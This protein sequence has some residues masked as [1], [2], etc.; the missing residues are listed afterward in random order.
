VASQAERLHTLRVK[1][2]A[3]SYT[4]RGQDWAKLFKRY[5]RKRS[6][7]ITSSEFVGAVRAQKLGQDDYSDTA[8]LRWFRTAARQDGT[9]GLEGFVKLL[10]GRLTKEEIAKASAMVSGS[11]SPSNTES[12]QQQLE[13]EDQQEVLPSQESQLREAMQHL[14]RSAKASTHE[15]QA[16]RSH[17]NELWRRLQH[18]DERYLVM[19]RAKGVGAAFRAW[20]DLMRTVTTQRRQATRVIMRLSRMRAAKS[21]AAWGYFVDQEQWQRSVLTRAVGRLLNQRVAAALAT[22]QHKVTQSQRLQSLSRGVIGRMMNT[23]LGAAFL[24]WHSW[25]DETR[26]QRQ[27]IARVLRLM[28]NARVASAMTAWHEMIVERKHL[29]GVAAR[30]VGKLVHRCVSC[31]WGAWVYYCC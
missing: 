24:T 20:A 19:Q 8:L 11:E 27:T 15:L 7:T 5:D 16:L 14:M 29:R 4:T 3:A 10:G 12:G 17:C 30:A 31:A 25:T 18:Y 23:T 22:W 26:R 2:Q 21:L 13:K 1:L 9:L 6:G 28:R